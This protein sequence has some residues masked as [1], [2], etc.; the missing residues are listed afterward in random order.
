MRVLI[1]GKY[2]ARFVQVCA[3]FGMS[4]AINQ[5]IPVWF[6]PDDLDSLNEYIMPDHAPMT[7]W[8]AIKHPEWLHEI[9]QQGSGVMVT[10]AQD[11]FCQLQGS[12]NA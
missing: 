2:L 10:D 3:D 6:G 11:T 4:P 1:R 9:W 12:H 5:S 8:I 7:S